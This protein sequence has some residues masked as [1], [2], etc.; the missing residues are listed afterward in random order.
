[1]PAQKLGEIRKD[2]MAGI[3]ICCYA[4]PDFR[5]RLR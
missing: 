5:I 2:T 3:T 1:M 4:V